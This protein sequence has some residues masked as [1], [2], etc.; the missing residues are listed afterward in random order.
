MVTSPRRRI[1]NYAIR[2]VLLA[3]AAFLLVYP[4]L[5]MLSTSFKPR[6]LVLGDPTQLI[7]EDPTLDNYIQVLGVDNFLRYFLNSA[8][9]AVVSTVLIVALSSMMAYAFSRLRFPGK[10]ILFTLIIVGLT[11]PTMMLI[12]PQFLLARDLHLL[13]SLQGLVPFYV[14]TALG[15][16]TFLLS[17]FFETIPKELDE[18]MLIDGAGP[19]RR[20]WSLALP[21]SKPALATCVIFAFLGT[22]DEFAWALTVLNDVEVRTLPIAIA[23]FQGQHSTSWGLVFAASLLAIIPVLIV[24]IVFQRF[25]VAGLTSGAIKS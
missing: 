9:V 7:P 10:R 13:N 8:A 17:G 22:W 15:F 21:L 3:I 14:G 4:F 16:N 11:I 25:F 1:L 2:Y 19:W 20:Y 24:Y 6:S 12:I 5:Y 23:L 18:A